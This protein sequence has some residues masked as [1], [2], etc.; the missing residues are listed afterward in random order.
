MSC[1]NRELVKF[2]L[3]YKLS[4][5][6]YPESLLMLRIGGEQREGEEVT[7]ASSNGVPQTPSAVLQH[8]SGAEAVKAAL[9]DSADE[10][11]LR[12]T[13]AFRNL[14]LKLDLTPDTVY[15]SFKSVMDE[16]FRDG[17][18]WGR[19]VGL[20]TFGGV[21]CVE[22][23]QRNM[24][25]LVPRIA[26][27]MTMYLDEYIDPWIQSQ[28]GW[29]RFAEIFGTDCIPRTRSCRD[30]VRRWLLVGAGLLAAVLIGVLITK[31]H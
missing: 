4:Q 21:L 24:S 11:E 28:G 2:F 12:F 29:D 18:N 3:G 6:N 22:C 19:I 20:F 27:W 17:V 15:H 10:F 26:D 30:T 31:K 9:K 14:F 1:S 16:V 8:C 13:Q 5:R 23:V 25:E 7:T